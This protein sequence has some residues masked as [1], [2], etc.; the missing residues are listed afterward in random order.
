MNVAV[1]E[2]AATVTVPLAGKLAAVVLLLDTVTV[3]PAEGANPLRVMVAVELFAP[4]VTL[5]G[6]RVNEA[7]PVATG[8]TVRAALL[9]TPLIVPEILAVEVVA[10]YGSSL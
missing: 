4:P 7:T 10:R 6:L 9:V 3:A 2:F 5:V 1:F 8:A